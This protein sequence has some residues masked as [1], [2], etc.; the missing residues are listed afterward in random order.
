M[1]KI[2]HDILCAI[3]FHHITEWILFYE[4]IG[5]EDGSDDWFTR[6]SGICTRCSIRIERDLKEDEHEL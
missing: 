2:L 4:E 3:G 6:K 5:T 1:K